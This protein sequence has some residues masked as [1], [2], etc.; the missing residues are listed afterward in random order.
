MYLSILLVCVS[1]FIVSIRMTDNSFILDIF[2][3]EAISS[4]NSKAVLSQ[5]LNRVPL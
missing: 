2:V 4:R 1:T 5:Y 3:F